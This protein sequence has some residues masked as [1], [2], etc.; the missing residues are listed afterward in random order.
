MADRICCINPNCRR[1]AAQD[2]FPRSSRI[3]CGK[4]WK[5]L[6][7]RMRRRHKQLNARDRLLERLMKKQGFSH[8]ARGRQWYRLSIQFDAAWGR[9]NASMIHFF[10]A[11]ETP[12]GLDDFLKENGLA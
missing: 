10:T 5:A 8:E 3:I 7:E 9:L 4:C 11:G 12:H 2:K 6:P 1:T